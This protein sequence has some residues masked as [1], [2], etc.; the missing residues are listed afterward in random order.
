MELDITNTE[1]AVVIEALGRQKAWLNA[2]GFFA[3]AHKVSDLQAKIKNKA[4]SEGNN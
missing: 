3:S 2:G 4:T 1:L